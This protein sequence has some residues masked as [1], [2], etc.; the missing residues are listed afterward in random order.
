M[1]EA[2]LR[3]GLG[4]GAAAA[5]LGAFALVA[6]ALLS[7]IS[8]TTTAM[9]VVFALAIRYGLVLVALGISLGFAYYAGMRVGRDRLLHNQVEGNATPVDEASVRSDRL[10]A[11]I[12]GGLTMVCYTIITTLYILVLPPAQQSAATQTSVGQV[13]VSRLVFAVIFVAFGAGLG[14]LGA[15]AAAARSLLDRIVVTPGTVDAS[16][17][18]PVA[19]PSPKAEGGSPPEPGS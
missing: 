2:S 10:D 9:A 4:M 16:V 19:A 14:G 11:A 15:R 13:L 3:W 1:R 8:K 17:G 5:A 7:P 12:A 18:L 6:G